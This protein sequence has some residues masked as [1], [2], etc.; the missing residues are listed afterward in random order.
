MNPEGMDRDFTTY[1][2]VS[3]REAVVKK[4]MLGVYGW[5]TIALL[6]TAVTGLYVAS[7][8]EMLYSVVKNYWLFAIAE[9]VIVIALGARAHKMSSL[10]AKIWFVIYSV[11]NG[12]TLS[13]IFVIYDIGTIGYAFLVTAGLF[14]VMTIYGYVTKTDLSKI[15]S[16]FVMALFGLVIATFVG[17]FINTPDYTMA[18]MY[19][20][21]FIFIGLIGWD[22]QK[23]KQYAYAQA[24]S[25]GSLANA[26]ILGALTLYLDFINIFIS[27][28]RIF[29]SRD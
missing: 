23:I 2:D 7:N 3:H 14:A 9:V 13:S 16:L 26:S 5:M 1:Y 22:T 15:G 4:T 25:N 6:I 8:I 21:V 10:S 28:V 12:I 27:L 24:D 19:V 17:F 29:G 20:T 11:L 18:L